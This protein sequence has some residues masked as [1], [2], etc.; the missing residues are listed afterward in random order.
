MAQEALRNQDIL[1]LRELDEVVRYRL[2]EVMKRREPVKE[3][4]R[5]VLKILATREADEILAEADETE[6]L[7]AQWDVLLRLADAEA[8]VRDLERNAVERHVVGRPRRQQIF[9]MV[10]A[11]GEIRFQEIK[12]ELGVSDANLSGLL[13]ELEAH[14]IVRRE[15]RGSETWV[16]L[17]TAGLAYLGK[18]VLNFRKR[19]EEAIQP[20]VGD[21]E[22]PRAVRFA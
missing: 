8:R 20:V 11:K 16:R 5:S 13:G 2:L 10:A 15:R 6:T 1:T 7:L 9:D 12:T 14:E 3:F 22:P 4:A 19:T 18:N 17:D 21:E